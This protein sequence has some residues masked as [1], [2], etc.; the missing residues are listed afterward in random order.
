MALEPEKRDE[1]LRV[2]LDALVESQAMPAGLVDAALESVLDR[3][4]L[5]STAIG[6]GVAVPHARVDAL[7]HIVV[8]FAHSGDGVEFKALDGEPVHDIFL[9]L[10]PPGA[11]EEYLALMQ[12]ITGLVQNEDFRRFVGGAKSDKDVLD[13]IKEMAS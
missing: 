7:D 1:A 13:L 3:E 12:Q 5:G 6:N 11:A 2:L 8:A 4:R 9:V 10:A